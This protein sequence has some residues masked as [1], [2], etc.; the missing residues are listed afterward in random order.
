VVPLILRAAAGKGN[1]N[2]TSS[3]LN[4]I[5]KKLKSGVLRDPLGIDHS[6]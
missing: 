6:L 2:P 1:I 5:D 4:S 3:L